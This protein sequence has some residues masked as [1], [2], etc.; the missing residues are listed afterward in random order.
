MVSGALYELTQANGKNL[1]LPFAKSL[2]YF[3]K[4]KDR[5]QEAA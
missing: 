3:E 5:G 4:P 1:L 2:R